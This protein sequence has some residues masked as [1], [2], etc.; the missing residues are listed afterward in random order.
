MDNFL[1]KYHLPKLNQK[2]IRKLNRPTTDKEIEKV[3]KS[4]PTKKKSPGTDDSI[5]FSKKN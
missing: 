3:I 4:L 2:Q 1:D 5:R